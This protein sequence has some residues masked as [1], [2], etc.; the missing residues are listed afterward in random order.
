MLKRRNAAVVGLG[1]L[2]RVIAEG[3]LAS[4]WTVTGYRRHENDYEILDEVELAVVATG[5]DDLIP[6]L[7]SIPLSWRDS[8]TVLLQN[9][10]LPDQWRSCHVIDPTIFIVWFSKKPGQTIQEYRPSL[11]F[12]PRAKEMAVAM[13]MVGVKT[14]TIVNEEELIMALVAKNTYIWAQNIVSLAVEDPLARRVLN[15][16]RD[17]L[18]SIISEV[19]T[20]QELT[21]GTHID[22]DSV[23]REVLEA[24]AKDSDKRLGGR[25]ARARLRRLL[26]L[27]T[28][29]ELQTPVLSSVEAGL[30]P[31]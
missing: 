29:V 15:E 25:T 24:I 9:E 21:I 19:I 20:V 28:S 14:E 7:S 16:H 23:V 27:A 22:R 1:Q 30:S 5:E 31:L 6:T 4:G 17:V 26:Q 10:L 3:L 18:D 2:G 8:K 12:G 11:L 13:E